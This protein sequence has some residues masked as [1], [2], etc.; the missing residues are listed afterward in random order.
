MAKLKGFSLILKLHP[1][2]FSVVKALS[3]RKVWFYWMDGWMDDVSS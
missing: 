2:Y 1:P 3:F